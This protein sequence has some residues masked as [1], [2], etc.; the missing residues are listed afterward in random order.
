VTG[1]VDLSEEGEIDWVQ[2]GYLPKDRDVTTEFSGGR[3]E[4]ECRGLNV[5]CVTR[6]ADAFVI[7]DFT[8]LGTEPPYRLYAGGAPVSFSWTGGAAPHQSASGVRAVVYQ[9]GPGAG[10][11]I[12]VPTRSTT[13]TFRL[14]VAYRQGA[15]RFSASLGKDGPPSYSDFADTASGQLN[16]TYFRVYEMAFRTPE[17]SLLEVDVTL[18][19]NHGGG[20]V[21]LMAATLR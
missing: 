2:W 21:T 1:N 12:L 18:E 11:R 13:R 6:K 17:P 14:Y 10:F 9:G 16:A 5:Y 4:T 15:M 19:R 20:N 8:A 3:A 7:G